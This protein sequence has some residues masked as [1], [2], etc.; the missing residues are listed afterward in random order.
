[1]AAEPSGAEC[2]Q[3]QA[4]YNEAVAGGDPVRTGEALV[5]LRRH[6]RTV[7]M[8]GGAGGGV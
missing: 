7:H 1:M 2:A 5:V 6:W 3:L 8:A 4:A